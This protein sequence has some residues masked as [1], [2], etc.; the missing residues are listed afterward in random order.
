MFLG[1]EIDAAMKSDRLLSVLLM[2]QAKGRATE[3]EL[4]ERLEV[5]QRTIHRDLEALSEAAASR[6]RWEFFLTAAPLAVPK[7]TGS[8]L[9]PIAIF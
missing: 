7:G 4:A 8:P 9:N 2:L 3:R 6:R 5:S 1:R